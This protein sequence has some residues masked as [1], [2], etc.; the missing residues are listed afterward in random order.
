MSSSVSLFGWVSGWMWLQLGYW[1][2]RKG[3]TT[4]AETC[5]RNGAAGKGKH[6]LEAAFRLSQ[7]LLDQGRNR[8]AMAA[9]EGALSRDAEHAKLW[10]AL[11]AARRRLAL[12]DSARE[13]YEKAIALAPRYAQAW[14][15]LGE[16]WMVKSDF[17]VALDRFERALDFEP[18][19]I[20]AL[21]NRV[22]VLYEMGRFGDAE[23]AA[24]E[25][26]EAHPG[27]AAL[28]VNLGN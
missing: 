16:W 20:E 27:E 28:H 3:M 7:R 2:E 13:A 22:A 12:M 15:N 24:R 14:C 5:Y 17:P 23:K 18:G 1:L 9:C 11:G 25:A 19:L 4:P 21:N 10:C 8:E 6:S 26:I